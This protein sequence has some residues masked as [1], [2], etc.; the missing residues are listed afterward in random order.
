MEETKH[1]HHEHHDQEHHHH[2]EEMTKENVLKLLG[3]MLDHNRHHTK[4]L[5]ESADL[6]NEDAAVLI[7]EAV[8]SYEAGNSRLEEALNKM[9][10]E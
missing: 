8:I 1:M 7:K 2:H 5:E 10:E 3:Y 6:V 9:K 4:E